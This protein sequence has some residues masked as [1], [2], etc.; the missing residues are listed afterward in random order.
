MS[1]THNEPNYS[2]ASINSDTRLKCARNTLVLYFLYQHKTNSDSLYSSTDR[3]WD[4]SPYHSPSPPK[5]CA[6]VSRGTKAHQ[7]PCALSVHTSCPRD[8]CWAISVLLP[9]HVALSLL[10]H[11]DAKLLSWEIFSFLLS[12]A[13]KSTD[14]TLFSELSFISR[15]QDHSKKGQTLKWEIVKGLSKLLRSKENRKRQ[16]EKDNKINVSVV[17]HPSQSHGQKQ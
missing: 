1:H 8:V 13:F 16:L 3:K 9:Q 4:L 7:G 5:G 17:T 6:K 15:H 11:L 10:L 14:H 2:V 12:F